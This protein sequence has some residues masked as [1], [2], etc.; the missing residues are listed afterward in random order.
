MLLFTIA[1]TSCMPT[2]P[3]CDATCSA[4]RLIAPLGGTIVSN[5]KPDFQ[6]VLPAG[7]TGA[8]LEFCRDAA[9]AETI[10]VEP[11]TGTA[12]TP[13]G[14]LPLG[15]LYWRAQT[16][17]G[18]VKGLT[19]RTRRLFVAGATATNARFATRFDPDDDHLAETVIASVP[20][21]GAGAARLYFGRIAHASSA[22]L[23]AGGAPARLGTTAAI[24]GDMSGDGIADFVV[25]APGREDE[26]GRVHLYIGAEGATKHAL[27]LSLSGY[28]RGDRFGAAIAGGLD[29]DGDGAPELAVGAPEAGDGRGSVYVFA[30]TKTGTSGAPTLVLRG[31]AGDH[32]G[33]ALANAFDLDGDGYGDVA[34]G[35]P[36]ADG[37]RGRVDIYFGSVT[38]IGARKTS[39]SGTLPNEAF[40]SALAGRSNALGTGISSVV[41]GCPRADDGAGRVDVFSGLPGGVAT[42][43]TRSFSGTPRSAFGYSLASG[44]DIDGDGLED[45]VVGAPLAA[46]GE[47][48]VVVYFGAAEGV[49]RGSVTVA[50]SASKE[51]FGLAVGL[52]GDLD[53]DGLADLVV[54]A[55]DAFFGTGR[56]YTFSGVR[57][58]LVSAP[59]VLDGIRAGER[60]GTAVN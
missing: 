3:V 44:G 16:T 50:G 40:G 4:P 34:I 21:S 33:A 57:G 15:S 13:K 35:A 25:G 1:I 20:E 41:V 39:R 8:S 17:N 47:G 53:G 10:A 6:W 9:C 28:E 48:Q 7:A 58:S 59:V 30:R 2:P 38:G 36:G 11:F 37:G 46:N 52:P 42:T 55:P 43:P 31:E 60:F 49:S 5:R 19:S 14:D 22:P 26:A 23:E 51:H 29:L 24:A 18:T 12:G 54:G 32:L 27:F 45:F 56:V